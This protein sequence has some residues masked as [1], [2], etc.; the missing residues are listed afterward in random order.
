MNRLIARAAFLL[1]LIGTLALAACGGS[2]N[3]SADKSAKETLSGVKPLQSAQVSAALRI[4]FDN[5]PPSVGD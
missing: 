5:A 3:E 2:D 4:F 1:L